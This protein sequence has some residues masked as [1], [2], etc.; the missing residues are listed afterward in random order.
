MEQKENELLF[1]KIGVIVKAYF[2]LKMRQ[3][4]LLIIFND[5]L[6]FLLSYFIK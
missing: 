2:S 6:L 5:A 3:I 4:V 1:E